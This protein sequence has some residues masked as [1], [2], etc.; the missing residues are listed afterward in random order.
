[1]KSQG[2]DKRLYVYITYINILYVLRSLKNTILRSIEDDYHRVRMKNKF[3]V[4]N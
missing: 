1:M 2:H 4:G 3:F